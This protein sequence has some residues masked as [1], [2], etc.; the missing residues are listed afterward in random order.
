MRYQKSFPAVLKE[1]EVV[2]DVELY[3][4]DKEE[5]CMCGKSIKKGHPIYSIDTA[6]GCYFCKNCLQEN[7]NMQFYTWVKP[8]KG[9]EG[10]KLFVIEDNG[11]RVIVKDFLLSIDNPFS[12]T[13]LVKKTD[14][15]RI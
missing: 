6:H 7:F 15:K 4:S 10:R 1:N 3:L 14:I 9:E 8:Q 13:E 12:S 5:F 11:D 2:E